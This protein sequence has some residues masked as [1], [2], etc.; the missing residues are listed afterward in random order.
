MS[1]RKRR[2]VKKSK[3]WKYLADVNPKTGALK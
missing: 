3:K 2:L 1:K